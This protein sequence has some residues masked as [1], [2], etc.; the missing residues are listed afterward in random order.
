MSE[1]DQQSPE[2]FAARCGSLGASS[3]AGITAKGRG[4]SPSAT[5]ANIMARLISER[6]TGIPQE[7]FQSAEMLHGIRTEP[8]ARAA[9]KFY[10]AVEVQQVGIVLHP[11]LKG[12]H[13][14]PD[15]LVGTD[16]LV[17]IKCPNTATHIDYLLTGS[18]PD[19]YVVQ[20]LWQMACTN[21]QYCDFVSYDP[22]MPEEL[23]MFVKRYD[24]D[25]HRLH[26]LTNEVADFLS[27]MESKLEQ[28]RELAAPGA[29]A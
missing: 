29:D 7:T 3:L 27:E 20:M 2:W 12:T 23:R 24:R 19:K 17:E 11:K 26:T 25:S 8:E 6:L 14:S 22:R 9:Y 15:G 18:I 10:C 16:G 1:M 5:R 13:A 4:G 21:R 28:L